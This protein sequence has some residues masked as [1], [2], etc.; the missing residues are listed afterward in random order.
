LQCFVL[1]LPNVS[2]F[3]VGRNDHDGFGQ[4]QARKVR[5]GIAKVMRNLRPG[6]IE[7]RSQQTERALVEQLSFD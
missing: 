2:L 4:S 6:M 3:M 5:I 1:E 7:G